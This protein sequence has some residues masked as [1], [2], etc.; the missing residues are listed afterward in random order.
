MARQKRRSSSP[1]RVLPWRRPQGFAARSLT[2]AESPAELGRRADLALRRVWT[3]RDLTFRRTGRAWL[4]APTIP[5]VSSGLR[6]SR[7][8]PPGTAGVACRRRPAGAMSHEAPAC[9]RVG[10]VQEQEHIRE[11]PLGA[12]VEPL[13]ARRRWNPRASMARH[14][15]TARAHLVHHGRLIDPHEASGVARLDGHADQDAGFRDELVL[16]HA[17]RPGEPSPYERLGVGRRAACRAVVRVRDGGQ[18]EQADRVQQGEPRV[19]VAGT[20]GPAS[21]QVAFRSATVI[22]RPR[23]RSIPTLAGGPRD[24]GVRGP[25]D[26][27]RR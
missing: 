22:T 17:A 4:E 12:W 10:Q 26:R 1:A 27:P 11:E 20:V 14:V 2:R 24:R 15:A 7:R 6:Y 25:P 5:V 13:R 21:T 8:G 16:R 19:P 18:M 3:C 23:G 9:I